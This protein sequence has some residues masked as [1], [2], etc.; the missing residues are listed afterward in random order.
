MT[1]RPLRWS[2]ANGSRRHRPHRARAANALAGSRPP[3]E[4]AANPFEL[5]VV[6]DRARRADHAPDVHRPRIHQQRA[7]GAIQEVAPLPGRSGGAGI[8]LLLL[9]GIEVAA[10]ALRDLDDQIRQHRAARSASERRAHRVHFHGGLGSGL[11]TEDGRRGLSG[12]VTRPIASRRS[13][14]F[15]FISQFQ[16]IVELTSSSR[17]VL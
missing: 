17:Q 9:L 6:G 4:E 16:R 10:P 14:P 12:S 8:Q 1:T 15:P 7:A 11:R 13:R 5:R 3:G 2:R